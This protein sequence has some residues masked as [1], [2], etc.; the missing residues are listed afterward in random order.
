VGNVA[1]RVDIYV[2]ITFVASVFEHWHYGA[3]Y[4]ASSRRAGRVVIMSMT[5][6]IADMLTRI[7]NGI[8][9]RKTRVRVPSSRIKLRIAEILQEEGFIR[10]I[11][12]SS[13]ARNHPVLELELK[14]TPESRSVI[15]GLKRISTPGQRLYVG[16]TEIPRVR[17]GQ[18]IAILTTS[19]GLMTDRSARQS[20][21]GGEVLCEVW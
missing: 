11:S 15:E 20:G 7:R 12:K 19:R 4:P 3:R 6:P 5:D 14:W 18:G 13:D 2:G 16:K 10:D 1:G 21:V 8:M 17:G 9:S